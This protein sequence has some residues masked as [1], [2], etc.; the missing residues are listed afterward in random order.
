MRK[1]LMV[2]VL[3]LLCSLTPAFA[4]GVNED[5]V[6]NVEDKAG[7]DAIKSSRELELGVGIFT[8]SLPHYLG[9]S[10]HNKYTVPLPYVRY[11]SERMSV[12]RNSAVGYLWQ[13]DNWHLDVSATAS[14]AVDS[15]DNQAR[16]GMD[17]LDWVFELGPA[18][19]YYFAGQPRS[20][21]YLKSGL[22][23]RKAL[24]TDFTSID[25]I[26]FRMGPY[27][28]W[29]QLLWQEA[30]Q[31]VSITARGAVN[32]AS[33]QYV[34]YFYGVG[35]HQSTVQR[36]AYKPQ[37]GYSGSELSVGVNYDSKRWWLGGFVK[38]Y[39]IKDAVWRDSPLVERHHNLAFGIGLAWKFYNVEGN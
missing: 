15:K 31:T 2:Y 4:A 21:N 28:Q 24:A 20:D 39:R 22:F 6:Q 10:E 8:T 25:D 12:D 23:V 5:S 11:R 16:S 3:L 37:S 38:Y 35:E 32:Y 33:S 19:D 34:D 1:G 27:M 30:E 18:L 13:S 9:S 29:Q 14:L 26:G 36:Q 17:D 7:K